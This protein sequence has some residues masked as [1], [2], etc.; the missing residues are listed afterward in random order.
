[1]NEE[2]LHA[3]VQNKNPC[4]NINDENPHADVIDDIPH[5]DINDE[6]LCADMSLRF[7]FCHTFKLSLRSVHGFNDETLSSYP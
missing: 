6:N 1:M 5:A 2:V 4:A 7:T 3:D